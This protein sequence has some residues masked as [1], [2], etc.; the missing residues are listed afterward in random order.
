MGPLRYSA[1][2]LH[3]VERDLGELLGSGYRS[4][5]KHLLA[6]EIVRPSGQNMALRKDGEATSTRLLDTALKLYATYGVQAVSLKEVIKGAKQKN[7]SALHYYFKDRDGL[8]DAVLARH[9]S[10][11]GERREH[12]LAIA[13]QADDAR[14]AAA[15]FVQP[16][17]ELLMEDWRERS[18]LQLAANLLADPTAGRERIMAVIGD[19]RADE[20]AELLVARIPDIPPNLQALRLR[21]G[22]LMVVQA[23]ADQARVIDSLSGKPN[24]GHV[25][26]FISNLIDMYLGAVTAPVYER[27]S[28]RK[29]NGNGKAGRAGNSAGAPTL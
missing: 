28:A 3:P 13:K 22:S 11:L 14:S 10:R 7:A 19:S 4:G 23:V 27:P 5:E 25:N 8:I 29:R 15:A 17:G 26:R 6:T 21:F 18:F 12:Y 20:A 9:V 24:A 1:G 2:A 16:L